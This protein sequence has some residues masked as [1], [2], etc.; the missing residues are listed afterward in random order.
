ME[1]ETQVACTIILSPQWGSR[2]QVKE[3]T[4]CQELWTLVSDPEEKFHTAVAAMTL[5]QAD[6]LWEAWSSL[7]LG[8][9]DSPNYRESSRKHYNVNVQTWNSYSVLPLW[10]SRL[11][12]LHTSFD[13]SQIYASRSDCSHEFQNLYNWAAFSPWPLGCLINTL[14]LPL[15][16]NTFKS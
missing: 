7:H 2:G 9:G 1:K 5:N 13:D 14:F 8:K 6:S 10:T 11:I 16:L 15:K 12:D 4:V 3:S